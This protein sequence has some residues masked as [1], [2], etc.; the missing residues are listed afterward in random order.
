MNSYHVCHDAVADEL[1]PKDTDLRKV[2]L[3]HAVPQHYLAPLDGGS[4]SRED[5][6]ANPD[7]YQSEFHTKVRYIVADLFSY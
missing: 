7:K 5:Y 4:Y 1:D 3:V 6:Y 2:Y